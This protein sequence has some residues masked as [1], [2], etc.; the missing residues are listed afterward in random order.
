V[1]NRDALDETLT[2][3]P[4]ALNNLFLA[5]DEKAGTLDTRAN[6][7]ETPTQLSAKQS[8]VLCAMLPDACKPLT[9]ITKL[10]GLGRAGA[11]TG[12]TDQRTTVVEPVDPTLG[13]LVEVTP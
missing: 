9:S 1:K 10:L 11:L 8:V 5:Y 2:T 7:G 13:G 4:V 12:S 3:A 6:V